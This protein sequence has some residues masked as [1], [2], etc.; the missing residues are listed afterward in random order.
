MPGREIL[1]K[2][3][4]LGNSCLHKEQKEEGMAML[5]KYKEAFSLRDEMGSCPNIEV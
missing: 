4:D 1:E 3:T 5:Y 2:Y